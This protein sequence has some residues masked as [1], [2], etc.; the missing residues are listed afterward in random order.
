[1]KSIKCLSSNSLKMIAVISMIIDHT[2]VVFLENYLV[3][4]ELFR[5]PASYETLQFWYQVNR[6]MRTMGRLAFPIFCYLIAEGFTHTR[7]SAKYAGRLLIFAAVSEIPFDI[8]MFGTWFYPR[9]QNVY[10]TL[11]LGLLAVMGLDRFRREE[12]GLWKQA[13][14]VI[15]SC[16]SAWMLKCDYGAFGVFLIILF[17]LLHG[18]RTRQIIM[19]SICLMWEPAAVLAFIPIFLYNGTRGKKN[20]K[21]FFYLFYP[22]HLAVLAALRAGCSLFFLK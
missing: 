4:G 3:Q 14:T 18:D 9:Y 21:W 10:V 16:G 17:Y 22:A 19:G 5:G 2:A 12:N 7:D 20:R 13:L 6:V 1:M 11:F 8:A 15:L